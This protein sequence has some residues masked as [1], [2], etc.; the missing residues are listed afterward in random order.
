MHKLLLASIAVFVS[1][2]LAFSQEN[3]GESLMN[4]VKN[5]D[6]KEVKRLVESG[7]PLDWEE[8]WQTP[9]S[10]AIT[11]DFRPI[12]LY[13]IEKG[14]ND[15]SGLYEVCAKNDAK[16][17]EQLLQYGFKPGDALIPASE[18]GHLEVVK[19][20]IANGASPLVSEKRRCGFLCKEYV[21]PIELA[22][23]NNHSEVALYLVDHGVPLESALDYALLQSRNALCKELIGRGVNL[24]KVFL[25]AISLGNKEITSYTLLKGADRFARD[26]NGKTALLLAIEHGNED[27]LYYTME[28]LKLDPNAVSTDGEN[29]LMLSC[30]SG[31]VALFKQ[32]LEKTT[33][34]EQTNKAGETV[35][36]Y[37][38]RSAN[39]EMINPLLDRK[40]NINHTSQSGMTPLMIAA[41]TLDH[42][43]ITRFIELGADCTKMNKQGQDVLAILIE[44][45]GASIDQTLLKLLVSKGLNVNAADSEGETLVFKAAESGNLELLQYLRSAGANFNPLNDSKQRP[46]TKNALVIRYLIENGADINAVDSWH[47]TYMCTAMSINDMELATFLVKKGINLE[48]EC[49]FQEPALIK[50]IEEKDLVFVRFLV[51]NGANVNVIGYFDRNAMEYALEKGTTEIVNYLRSKGAMTPEEHK[52]AIVKQMEEIGKLNTLVSEGKTAEVLA[53]MKKYPSLALSPSEVNALALLAVESSSVELLRILLETYRFDLNTKINF[54]EQTVLFKA[55]AKGNKDF[56]LLLLNKGADP[57]IKDAFGK[58]AADYVSVKEHKKMIRDFKK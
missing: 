38:I 30:K 13:L 35:L 42:S 58:D 9:L 43:W 32:F 19:V 16:W 45:S 52:V 1:V 17:V 56:I 34:L 14:A 15:R 20:L 55:A 54:E 29:A 33:T 24:N 49:Y 57:T 51:D 26:E 7:A 27:M 12:A 28:E 10:W 18:N 40:A 5:N 41:E 44:K 22:I 2:T 23:Q 6:L 36:F 3:K 50:A 8:S 46:E 4:A 48:Q 39:E 31:K 11:H 25:Q 37:A 47:S 53:L 21:T